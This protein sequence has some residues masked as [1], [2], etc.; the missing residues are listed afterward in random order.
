LIIRIALSGDCVK[1]IRI[2]FIQNNTERKATIL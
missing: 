1:A 2:D